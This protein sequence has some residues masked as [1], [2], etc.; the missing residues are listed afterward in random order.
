MARSNTAKTFYEDETTFPLKKYSTRLK[1]E[2]DMLHQ[3]GQARSDK[4]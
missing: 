1:R 2:F 4:E 3:Y